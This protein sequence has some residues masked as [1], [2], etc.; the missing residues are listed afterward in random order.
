MTN[1]NTMSLKPM[2][3]RDVLKTIGLG[4]AFLLTGA[5]IPDDRGKRHLITL[6]YD[7][8]FERS[9]IK[10]AEIYEKYGLSASINVIASA[11]EKQ[12]ELP[13]EYHKW[14]VGDFELWNEL[15]SRGHE[16]MP[17]SYKHQNLSQIPF[18]EA[19]ELILICLDVFSKELDGFDAKESIFN[20]PYNAS[21]PQLEQWLTIQVKAF[22]TGGAAVNPLPFK[23]MKR[24]T[25]ASYGPENI[26][27]HLENTINEFLKG[28]SGWLIFN[29]HGLDEEGWGPMSSGFLDEL[30]DRLT[31]LEHVEVL[32][33]IPALDSI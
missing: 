1:K 6:S 14:P 10:T 29:T 5:Y 9:S 20:F 3:R 18:N 2:T 32:P 17:H 25:C 19:Q 11:H 31:G 7:D 28:P 26:D 15:K 23:G 33:V 30:L 24:L 27:N 12:F 13:N 16:I 4:S 8:G 21:T 22:R